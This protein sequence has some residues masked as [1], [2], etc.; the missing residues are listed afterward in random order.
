MYTDDMT[1]PG[2]HTESGCG[3]EAAEDL[4]REALYNETTSIYRKT[5][6]LA[7]YPVGM[8]FAPLQRF[9]NIYDLDTA[10]ARGTVFGELDLPF[11]CGEKMKGGGCND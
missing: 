8:V 7:G 4:R 2:I 1:M 10:L 11:T 6:G 3:C 9:D 5:W